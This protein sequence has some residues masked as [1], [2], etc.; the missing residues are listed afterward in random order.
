MRAVVQRVSQASVV[1][2][3]HT[4]ARVGHGLLVLVAALEGDGEEDAD[5]VARKI[6]E[7]RIFED[8]AGKMN[9]SGEDVGGAVLVVS[10][11]TLAGD[12][13][14]GRR[15]SFTGALQPAA[16]SPLVDRVTQ[17]LR[18]RGLPVETGVFGA[19]MDVG[20]STGA[21]CAARQP[22]LESVRAIPAGT[23]M[24]SSRRPRSD[25]AGSSRPG[26][27]TLRRSSWT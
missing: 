18:A 25:G 12:V 6:A 2:S 19:S 4:V 5:Y 14:K 17:A 11:F 8:D 26:V 27:P 16:A 20:S 3:G 13:R 15:P 1:V 7:M 21:P 22:R 9:R 23:G 10:Q 24:A